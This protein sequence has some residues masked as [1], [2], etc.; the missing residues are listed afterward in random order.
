MSNYNTIYNWAK[1]NKDECLL[2]LIR[3]LGNRFTF[4]FKLHSIDNGYYGGYDVATVLKII[5]DDQ[6]HSFG[7]VDMKKIEQQLRED[8]IS[9]TEAVKIIRE[10]LN[11]FFEDHR[12]FMACGLILSA[13]IKSVIMNEYEYVVDM[14]DK[15]IGNECIIY[16]LSP[17]QKRAF[18][19]FA[20]ANGVKF[21]DTE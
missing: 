4:D 8:S 20:L 11:E 21:R 17:D 12:G 1:Q 15:V 14:V 5:L 3:V 16:D 10:G 13:F 19:E 9:F 7:S 6:L 2:N 18:I